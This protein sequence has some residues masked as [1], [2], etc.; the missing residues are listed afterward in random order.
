MEPKPQIPSFTYIMENLI[1]EG[2]AISNIEIGVILYSNRVF[3]IIT[4]MN[5][6]GNIV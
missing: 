1:F 6:M 4:Q 5:K 3:F 2:K